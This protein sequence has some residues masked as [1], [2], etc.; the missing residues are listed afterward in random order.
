MFATA[1]RQLRYS[2][3]MLS[4]RRLPSGD[5]LALVDDIRATLEEFGAPGDGAADMLSMPDQQL[6]R[7]LTRRRLRRTIRQAARDTP[8]YRWWFGMNGLDP[9]AVTLESL[10]AVAPTP[11]SAL[12]GT[13]ALF[14]S[15]NASP[16]LAATTTG[17]TGTPTLVWFSQYELDVACALT[18]MAMMLGIGMRPHHVWANCISSRSIP[19]FIVQ[20]A[21][22]MTGAAFVPVGLV[23]P[24]LALDRLATP[25][26]IP[27]K[28]AQVT[29]LNTTASYLA[30]LVQEAERGGWSARDFALTR[31]SS[32]GEVLTDALRVRAEEAFGA[33][34]VDGYAMTEIVPVAGEVCSAGHLHVAVEQGLVEVLDPVDHAPTAAGALGVL[35]VT[36]YA[37]YRDTTVLL[38]YLT[39]D[40]VRVLPDGDRLGCELAGVPATSRVLGRVL[41]QAGGAPWSALTTRDVLDLLQAERAVPLPTRFALEGTPNGPILHVMAPGAGRTLLARIEERAADLALPLRGVVLVDDPADLPAP[42]PVRADLREG[43]FEHHADVPASRSAE[44]VGAHR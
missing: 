14:V 2:F 5:L 6:Q 17:T 23:A 37:A 29:H 12:R 31:I 13:P 18:A 42:C 28:S 20:R 41:P 19:H 25:H 9:S 36:P 11:K 22:A 3:S 4:G 39:G 15:D 27:R 7:D 16:V 32:G 38:R 26:H 8:Y 30:A 34:V 44:T 35:T 24:A 1:L 33:P 10:G 43:S 40:L 21:V